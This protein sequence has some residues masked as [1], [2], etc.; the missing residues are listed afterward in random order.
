MCVYIY[1]NRHVYTYLHIC[2]YSMYIGAVCVYIYTYVN[3]HISSFGRFCPLRASTVRVTLAQQV[4]GREP[5]DGPHKAHELQA[6]LRAEKTN[7]DKDP[8]KHG[9]WYP[10]YTGPW[11]QN[12]RSLCLGGLLSIAG[13]FYSLLPDT[14]S[15]LIMNM[16]PTYRLSL[17][18]VGCLLLGAGGVYC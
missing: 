5:K 18:E 4:P 11:N 14:P 12:V 17:L 15:P 9:F 7:K 13:P 2:I 8:T 1:T 10:A 16:D 6:M 3:R